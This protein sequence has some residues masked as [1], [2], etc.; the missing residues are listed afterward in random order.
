[1]KLA[2]G[3]SHSLLSSPGSQASYFSIDSSTGDVIV[4]Q[5]LDRDAASAI[6]VF[7]QLTVTVTDAAGHR[8]THAL[9]LTLTD[10]NDNSPACSPSVIA[11]SVSEN[12]AAGEC[13]P[14]SPPPPI[15]H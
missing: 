13:S 12:T 9:Q 15:T 4:T 1:M 7:D 10:I 8:A 11:V 5:Q 14:L 2:W 6:T 3:A